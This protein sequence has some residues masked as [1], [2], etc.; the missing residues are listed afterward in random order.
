MSAVR[1]L[2]V[3]AEA[4]VTMAPAGTV[5]RGGYLRT[6]G[7]RVVETGPGTPAPARDE[8]VRR[9]DG[10]VVVPGLV[11]THHHLCQNLTRAYGP[12]AN[13]KLFDWLVALY[14]VWAGFDPQNLALAAQ[15]GFAELLLSGCTTTSDHH[16]L[17]PRG[18]PPDLLDATIH[19]ARDL[20]IRFHVTRGSMSVGESQ[21]GLPPDRCTQDEQDVLRDCQRV[22]ETWHDPQP[23]AM[24]RVALAPCS[25]FSVSADLMRETALLAR[26]HGVRL[27]THLAETL[28][29]ERYCLERFARRPVDFL[30]DVGWMGDDVWL[31]HGIH[32]SDAEVAR[33]GRRRIGIAHCPTSN[34]R[35]GSGICR[36]ADL[37]AA[38]SP[39][40]LGVDGS[41][42]NDTGHAL[43]EVRQA[44]YLRRL[45]GGASAMTVLEALELAT[46]GGAACLGRDDIGWLGPGAA[47]DFA[48][49]DRLADI[50]LSGA[51]DPVAALLLCG[52][53]RARTVVVN[54]RVVV[55]E[56]ELLTVD[57]PTLLPRHREAA[58]K[59]VEA[60]R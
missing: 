20:G 51:H 59:L 44:L 48:V 4:L 33:L 38:G 7:H 18:A 35:L 25:P 2:W 45:V 46:R 36:V 17:F 13:A 5:I 15:V 39:V 21:G 41:A 47:A 10:C 40:G 50:A 27:H 11:N 28:D 6:E 9:L 29:E 3:G 52:P 12:A 31:A 42:S 22:V 58:Q 8:V 43:H 1:T 53:L 60:A 26:A 55:D 37:R 14:P 23:Y 24:L 19:A 54:G 16:Y 32:F 30:E 49:F 34:M 56:G 57:L